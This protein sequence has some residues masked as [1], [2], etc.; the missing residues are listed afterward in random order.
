MTKKWKR[1]SG[2][3]RSQG[4]PTPKAPQNGTVSDEVVLSK[5]KD[6]I[7]AKDIMNKPVPRKKTWWQK[8]M[9]GGK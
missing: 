1:K 8:L 5:F 2:S 3:K 6:Y 4:V 7:N 9:G